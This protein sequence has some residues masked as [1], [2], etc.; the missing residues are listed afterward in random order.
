VFGDSVADLTNQL[1][2]ATKFLV[3]TAEV[4]PGLPAALGGPATPATQ[5]KLKTDI[6]SADRF[7]GVYIGLPINTFLGKTSLGEMRGTMAVV[8]RAG[9]LIIRQAVFQSPAGTGDVTVNPFTTAPVVTDIGKL[10]DVVEVGPSGTAG[11]NPFTTS[12]MKW[13]IA[14]GAGNGFADVAQI[15]NVST[16]GT[17]VEIEL[18][19]LSDTYAAL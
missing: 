8:E 15:T 3:S 14:G 19:K 4:V 18:I 12:I 10:V 5:G 11:V 13:Q 2:D 6:E 17:E 1:K 16:D 9:R 7:Y